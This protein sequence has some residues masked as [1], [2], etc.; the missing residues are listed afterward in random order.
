MSNAAMS[1]ALVGAF[2]GLMV[3]LT[4]GIAHV[5]KVKNK[6]LVIAIFFGLLVFLPVILSKMTGL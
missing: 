2:M 5:L 3:M 4:F 1:G 6:W